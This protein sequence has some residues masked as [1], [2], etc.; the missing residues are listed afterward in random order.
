MVDVAVERNNARIEWLDWFAARSK[1]VAELM[2]RR[3]KPRQTPEE[4][5]AALE[6][7]MLEEIS[8]KR[9]EAIKRKARTR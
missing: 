1:D 9:V 2:A 6:L 3:V 8:H 5:A 7:E 4:Y